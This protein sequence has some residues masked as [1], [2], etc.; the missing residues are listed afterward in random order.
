MLTDAS[1]RAMRDIT[2]ARMYKYQ[3]KSIALFIPSV[4]SSLPAKAPETVLGLF[5]I[6]FFFTGSTD[7]LKRF[8]SL[9][10]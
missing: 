10:Q 8:D 7:S 9:E 4:N 5:R 1:H 3:Y 2:D 6:F